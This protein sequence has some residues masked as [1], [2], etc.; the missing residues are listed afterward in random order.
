[1]VIAKFQRQY[2]LISL[3]ER[4]PFMKKVFLL[5]LIAGIFLIGAPAAS[6]ATVWSV[7]APC[8]SL[9]YSTHQINHSTGKMGVYN[10]HDTPPYLYNASLSYDDANGYIYGQI[11][12]LNTTVYFSS[13]DGTDTGNFI[14]TYAGA[15]KAALSCDVLIENYDIGNGNWYDY[16]GS[17]EV[18]IAVSSTG[19]ATFKVSSITASDA[20]VSN[21]G[22]YNW[23]QDYDVMYKTTIS[24]IT[25]WLY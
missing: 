12:M 13:H 16:P 15:T 9:S 14:M 21:N 17:A 7:Y 20:Y 4:R 2:S 6:H 5:S 1:M 3:F 18:D 8:K 10:L 25:G 23:Y 22:G 19:Q 11:N 24:P